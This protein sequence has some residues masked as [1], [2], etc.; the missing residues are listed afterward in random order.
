MRT[1]GNCFLP[2]LQK[3]LLILLFASVH[4]LPEQQLVHQHLLLLHGPMAQHLHPSYFLGSRQIENLSH[5]CNNSNINSNSRWFLYKTVICRAELK[6]STMW[7]QLFT[8]WATSSLNWQPWFLSKES[9]QS[10]LMKTWM[11]H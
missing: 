1:E 6:L 9:L 7:N 2:L 8:S 10:G 4:W 3:I 5:F 11:I